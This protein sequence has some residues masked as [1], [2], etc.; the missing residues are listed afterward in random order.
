M[1]TN[2]DAGVT[3]D[4]KERAAVAG[5]ATAEAMVVEDV[6][7]VAAE[8]DWRAAPG[9]L[10]DFIMTADTGEPWTLPGDTLE[11][12]ILTGPLAPEPDRDVAVAKSIPL[13]IVTNLMGTIFDPD[14]MANRPEAELM[15]V[16][17]APDDAIVTTDF[18]DKAMELVPTLAAP[19]FDE[20]K[21]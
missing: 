15:R 16:P 9:T 17:P 7:V 2:C 21:T 3:V 14:V 4:D 18:D 11:T 10:I 1:V 5:P 6:V 12:R 19:E 8:P 13:G 20:I